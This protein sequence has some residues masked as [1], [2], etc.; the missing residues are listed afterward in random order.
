MSVLR[1]TMIMTCVVAVIA[2]APAAAE[3]T[4]DP[5]TYSADQIERIFKK[6]RT[7]G[8]ATLPAAQATGTTAHA[9]DVVR[10]AQYVAVDR[11][12]QIN[13]RISFDFDSD[14]LR[15]DQAAMLDT[16]CG[17]MRRVDVNLFQI[18]GHTD[19]SGSQAYNLTLSERRARAVKRHL[20]SDCGIPAARLQVIGVGERAL[21]NPDNPLADENRRVEFQA[22]G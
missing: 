6:Q 13:I 4:Q 15:R 19:G 18:I 17:V 8:I 1:S 20:V 10:E 16:L 9:A 5:G 14:V 7:R 3:N 11:E 2:A 12:E 21:F 22:L